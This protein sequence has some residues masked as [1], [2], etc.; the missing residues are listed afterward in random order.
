MARR[1]KRVQDVH[2]ETLILVVDKVNELIAEYETKKQRKAE[3]EAA[4]VAKHKEN[5]QKIGSNISFD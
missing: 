1:S 5:V 4:Q 3:A 2:R